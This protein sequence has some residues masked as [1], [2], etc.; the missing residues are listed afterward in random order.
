MTIVSSVFIII[1]Y[2]LTVT[3][4]AETQPDFDR[5]RGL[6][7]ASAAYNPGEVILRWSAPG[8]DGYSG[9]AAGY[10]LRCQS[11]IFGPIDTENEWNNA[12]RI[13]GEPSPSPAGEIDTILIRGLECGAAYYFCIKTYDFSSNFSEMSNSPVVETGDCAD[14]LYLEGDVDGSGDVNLFDVTF[15]ISYLYKDGSSPH[16]PEAGDVDGSSNTVIF[17]VTYLIG[18]LY[19][20]GPE[21]ICL[22]WQY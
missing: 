12:S 21:P 14:C 5:S 2:S 11:S 6:Q 3:A 22:L 7:P 8:N 17:D 15:L 19:K 20:D 18:F 1:W 16:P 9:R 13:S 10:D 4:N